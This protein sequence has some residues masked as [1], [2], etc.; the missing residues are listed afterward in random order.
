MGQI[1][2]L[3]CVFA[4]LVSLNTVLLRFY[5]V[6]E[7]AGPGDKW[8]R[9]TARWDLSPQSLGGFTY[10]KLALVSALTLFLE[11]LMIRWVSSEVRI[12]AY[13]KNFVLVACFLGFGVGCYLCRRR[14]S[15]LALVTPVVTVAVLIKWPSD[16][17]RQ[18]ITRLPDYIG[19]FSDVAMWD[20]P[21]MAQDW[22]SVAMMAAAAAI[23]VALF[24]LIAFIFIPLGQFVGWYL[25]NA[26][27]GIRGYSVNI[28]GSLAGIGFY[29]LLC[30]LDQ[31]PASWLIAAGA[32]LVALVWR[33]PTVR[34]T[35][36]L[37]FG[38]C[39]A[40]ASLPSSG[41][42]TTY[43]SPYQKL[44]LTP[45]RQAGTGEL[46]AY[47][48]NTNGTWY[49]HI[50]DLSPGFVTRHPGLFR[51]GTADWEGY[52]L[53]YH[54]YAQP[55]AVL[56]LGA[57]MGNDVAAALRHGAQR[58][59]AVEI[60]PLILDLGR[61]LH[62]EK[63]Y[64]SPKVHVVVDDARSYVQNASDQFDLIVFSLL[65]SHTTSSSY[66]NIRI[67]NYV[68]TLEAMRAARRLLKPDG[69]FIV[70]FE[71]HSP[72][73]AGRLQEL[74]TDVFGSEPLQTKS[75]NVGYTSSGRFFIAGSRDRIRQALADPALAAYYQGH[76]NFETAAVP[77]TTDDWPYFYQSMPG[78]P[79]SVVLISALLLVTGS[80][81]LRETGVSVTSLRW[82]FFFLGAGFMLL[83]AQIIS[84][85]A[86]LFGT[87]WLVNSIV[88]SGLLLLIV[89]SN[90]LA[91]WKPTFPRHIA[92]IGIFASL[93]MAYL[94]PVERFLFASVWLK[95]L[96]ASV[97]LCLP[98]FFAGIVF[99][100][101]FARAQFS[102]SALGSNLLGAL[103]GGL[104]ESLSMWTGIRSLLIVATVFYAASWVSLLVTAPAAYPLVH[105]V[106]TAE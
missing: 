28:L 44:T 97:V 73:I 94:L 51:G 25:E 2:L 87:T 77:V 57:G 90:L 106:T 92:Y 33:N 18:L 54:F 69:L 66:S 58:V 67:D 63:P 86:L 78:L 11:L 5:A 85:M 43:W 95:W 37:S 38:F 62:F 34:W 12:F 40:L 103:V 80:R 30:F 21:G 39:A 19:A 81:F 105:P 89:G 17:L 6:E 26:N 98:V 60:D 46:L 41:G 8:R 20:M 70:K 31:P 9:L 99:I 91:E 102:G 55:P 3:L 14:A 101:S 47:E 1:L 23:A 7:T 56:V 29:T 27:R 82:H 10:S 68:Y 48:L 16:A 59:I 52:N 71:V 72:F 75:D 65:D 49:Q 4:A 53:P 32:L 50:L 24:S 96:T 35:G 79:V 45:T 42:G 64:S 83:E 104:L 76:R 36:A 22:S 84:K 15:L 88:I 100:K 61:K 93:L 13:F 74:L